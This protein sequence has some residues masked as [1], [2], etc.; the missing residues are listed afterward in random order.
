[1][2]NIINVF[3]IKGIFNLIADELVNIYPLLLVTKKMSVLGSS[4]IK[5]RIA[6]TVNT[7]IITNDAGVN[8]GSRACSTSTTSFTTSTTS[9]AG[10][11]AGSTGKDDFYWYLYNIHKYKLDKNFYLKANNLDIIKY[12]IK[13]GANKFNTCMR[14][15]NMKIILFLTNKYNFCFKYNRC[16]SSDNLEVHDF[17][18]KKLQSRNLA[19]DY[20]DCF[21][22]GNTSVFLEGRAHRRMS[23]DGM[24]SNNLGQA[25]H[26]IAILEDRMDFE[27]DEYKKCLYSKNIEVIKI[28]LEKFENPKKCLELYSLKFSLEAIVYIHSLD[29]NN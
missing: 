8:N 9:E 25:K 10:S 29:K 17:G 12:G 6:N 7:V 23:F 21:R 2:S 22:S 4:Y 19:I 5:N 14:T 27:A 26:C 3:H 13:K 18:I 28:C 1:M 11:K 24:S 20:K 16:L 15:D